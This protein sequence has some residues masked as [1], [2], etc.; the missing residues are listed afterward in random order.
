MTRARMTQLQQALEQQGWQVSG[1]FAPDE[2]FYV[3]RERIV[4]TLTHT[5][6]GATERLEFQL[7]DH[8]GRI[9]ERLADISHVDARDKGSRLYFDKILSEQWGDGLREFV[10]GLY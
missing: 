7:S 9:T 2:L 5:G 6:T 10:R 1:E 3:E 8:L 4:W